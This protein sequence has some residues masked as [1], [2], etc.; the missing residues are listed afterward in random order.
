MLNK[1][2]HLLLKSAIIVDKNKQKV[3]YIHKQ[4]QKNTTLFEQF[5]I[6]I[7]KSYSQNRYL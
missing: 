6:P 3:Q 4:K 2:Y 1:H 7:V 5:Q